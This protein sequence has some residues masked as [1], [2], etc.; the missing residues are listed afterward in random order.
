VQ[1]PFSNNFD[2]SVVWG[3]MHGRKIYL[4]FRWAINRE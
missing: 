4:G 2:A 1:H 3:P